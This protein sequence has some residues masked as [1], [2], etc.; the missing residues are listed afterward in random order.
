MRNR[1]KK[2]LERLLDKGTELFPSTQRRIKLSSS[3]V[4]MIR[5]AIAAPVTLFSHKR[6]LKKLPRI[7]RIERVKKRIS[8]RGAGINLREA[9]WT[10]TKYVIKPETIGAKK[11]KISLILRLI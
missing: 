6:F 5:Q 3:P 1:P 9:C 10:K 8:R 2:K 4:K 11:I 7:K